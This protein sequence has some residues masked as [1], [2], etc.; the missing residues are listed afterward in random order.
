MKKANENQLYRRKL[1][2]LCNNVKCGHI[3]CSL[4][5]IDIIYIIFKIKN[6]SERFILSKG[7]AA[8]ALYTILNSIGEISNDELT[9]F[10]QNGTKLSAHPSANSYPNIPFALG[11]LGHGLPISC[12]IALAN[13]I[14]N[15]NDR[16]FILMSDGETNEGTTW[17]AA[18]FAVSNSLSNLILIID[19]NRLQGFGKT[20]DIFG[21]TADKIK[22][23][24]IG[25]YVTEIDGHNFD[26]IFYSISESSNNT[27]TK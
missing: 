23:E 14:A 16:T 22:W 21:D 24:C 15:I 6:N 20:D 17:E 18:H 10:Y 1:I 19:K 13:K 4:S 3:A 2:E 7:H 27:N 12:G 5:C 11:S 25:F 9:T 8:A 26:E